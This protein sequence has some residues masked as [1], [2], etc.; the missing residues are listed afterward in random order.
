MHCVGAYGDVP[1][2]IEAYKFVGPRSLYVLW[3]NTITETVRIPST[4]D[5]VLTNRDGDESTV[6]PAQMGVV[7]FEV[8]VKPVFV[9]IANS[10]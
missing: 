4:V 3:S 7:E 5:A 8:G 9:E 1:E 6:L 2:E 10:E